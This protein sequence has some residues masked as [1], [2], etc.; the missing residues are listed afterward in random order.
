MACAHSKTWAALRFS[1]QWHWHHCCE[2]W[3]RVSLVR[4]REATAQENQCSCGRGYRAGQHSIYRFCF[5]RGFAKTGR[6]RQGLVSLIEGERWHT[7]FGPGVRLLP[8]E[9]GLP[10][11]CLRGVRIFSSDAWSVEHQK[12]ARARPGWRHAS[13]SPMHWLS[14]SRKALASKQVTSTSAITRCASQASRV[15]PQSRSR[16]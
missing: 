2:A 10:R 13:H 7:G 12:R 6:E 14:A 11:I 8:R 3:R 15:P 4:R 5:W 16:C 9:G 1:P